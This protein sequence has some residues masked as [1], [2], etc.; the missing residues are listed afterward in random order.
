MP[1]EVAREIVELFAAKPQVAFKISNALVERL[2]DSSSWAEST[3]IMDLIEECRQFSDD[4]LER[5]KAAP[6]GN[7]QVRD[8]WGVPERIKTIVEKISS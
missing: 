8:A 5:L 4:A 2:E 3:R 6:K 1:I 7:P